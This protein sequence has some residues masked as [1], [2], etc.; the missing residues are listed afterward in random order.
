MHIISITK[1]LK[2]GNTVTS[3]KISKISTN[4]EDRNV[5]EE[6]KFEIDLM[7]ITQKQFEVQINAHLALIS[8]QLADLTTFV[9]ASS[10]I[11]IIGHR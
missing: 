6:V 11:K 9:D 2:S 8:Q 10:P 1:N 4:K 3:N 5:N 7:H